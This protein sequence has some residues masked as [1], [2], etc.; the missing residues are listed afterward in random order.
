MNNVVPLRDE[1]P[2]EVLVESPR[3]VSGE[4]RRQALVLAA[5]H[6]IAER[7]FEGLRTRDVAARAGVNVAT[8]HYHF[9]TKEALIWA[10]RDYISAQFMVLH[11]PGY[12]R[13]GTPLE[14]LRMEFADAC[15]YERERPELIAVLQELYL[16]GRRDPLVQA[17]LDDI[18]HHW[19]GTIEDIL[20]AGVDDG[21]F[22]ADLDLEVAAHIIV[23]FMRGRY[24]NGNGN[25][26]FARA[27]AEIERWLLPAE[28]A[29]AL[30]PGPEMPLTPDRKD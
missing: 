6:Q 11:H 9:T 7:G 12:R 3:G 4:V 26:D 30:T 10:V 29:T 23:T 28:A 13:T 18:G 8:L 16:R 5:F 14:R 1:M 21:T 20:R 19:Q 27:C 17:V 24:F 25:A 15:Y 2:E 22:R